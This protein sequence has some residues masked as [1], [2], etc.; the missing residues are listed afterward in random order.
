MGG[1]VIKIEDFARFKSNGRTYGGHAGSKKGIIINDG[2][3]FIK[4]PKSTKSMEVTKDNLDPVER[5]R[6]R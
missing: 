6:K 4:Y 1:I 5:I 2:D 3:W